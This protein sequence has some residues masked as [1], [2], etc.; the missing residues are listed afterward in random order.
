MRE[1]ID[2][3][4]PIKMGGAIPSDYRYCVYSAVKSEHP[5]MTERGWKLCPIRGRRQG[6]LLELDAGESELRV[7]IPKSDTPHIGLGSVLRVSDFVLVL[8]EPYVQPL[9]SHPVITS[10]LVLVT[11]DD[12]PRGVRGIDYGVHIGKRVGVTLGHLG[13]GIEVGDRVPIHVSGARCFGHRVTLKG[14]SDEESIHLQSK[15]IGQKRAMG[16][17]VFCADH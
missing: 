7:R 8:G 13:V 3:V 12:E 17:G 2:V 15:G 16:C 6:D 10:D 1:F 5:D 14:L 11:S 4:Y 9:H